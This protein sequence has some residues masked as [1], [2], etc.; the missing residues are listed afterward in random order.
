MDQRVKCH[1]VLGNIHHQHVEAVMLIHSISPGLVGTVVADDRTV[2]VFER[3]AVLDEYI[4]VPLDRRL[5]V[6]VGDCLRRADAALQV[7]HSSEDLL[8]RTVTT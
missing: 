8:V 2:N 5:G 4:D 6:G 1:T 7:L 3:E